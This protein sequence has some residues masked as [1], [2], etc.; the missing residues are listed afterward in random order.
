MRMVAAGVSSGIKPD[1]RAR[2]S[3]TTNGDPVAAQTSDRCHF[4]SSE[5]K[6]EIFQSVFTLK[7][8]A[9]AHDDDCLV[10]SGIVKQR[11]AGFY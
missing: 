2:R 4:F 7:N 10:S 3:V 11:V 8:P 6:K 5:F 1:V 9:A